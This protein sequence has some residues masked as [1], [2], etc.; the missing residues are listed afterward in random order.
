MANSI[1][2]CV[3]NYSCNCSC[4][5]RGR[6]LCYSIECFHEMCSPLIWR[7]PLMFGKFVWHR[8]A[9]LITSGGTTRYEPLWKREHRWCFASICLRYWL[10][11]ICLQASF[12]V[13]TS[14]TSDQVI[15]FDFGQDLLFL[16][17]PVTPMLS[18]ILS[19]SGLQ[20]RRSSVST[21]QKHNSSSSMN[22]QTSKSS[23]HSAALSS[24]PLPP[25][26]RVMQNSISHVSI[27]DDV[28]T[29]IG[30]HLRHVLAFESACCVC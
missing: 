22:L 5:S 25:D 13:P 19:N 10:P 18:H 27:P 7:R 28:P 29:T 30:D 23:L 26:S 3:N 11:C 21:L 17:D 14:N 24:S 20:S 2:C 1:G 9:Q 16:V 8:Q 15:Y 12:D 4:S 6:Y